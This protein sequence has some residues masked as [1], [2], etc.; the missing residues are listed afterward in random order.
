[1][2]MAFKPVSLSRF[3]TMD[4]PPPVVPS[5][6]ST[7]GAF[8]IGTFLGLILYGITVHQV[9]RYFRV[10]AQD[11]KLLKGLVICIF[12]I[13]TFH[14][15]TCMHA[16]YTYL[17]TNYFN[18]AS[19][20]KGTW[21]IQLQ[22]ITCAVEILVA[23]SFYSRRAFLLRRK[24]APVVALA[25]FC[26]F[27]AFGFAAAATVESIVVKTFVDFEKYTWLVSVAFGAA[28]ASDIL[29]TGMLIIVLKKS[30]TGIKQTDHLIDRLILYAVNTGLLTGTLNSLA[31]VLIRVLPNLVSF[32][33]A[34]VVT[35]V[36]ANS[37]LAVL[38]TRQS[39]TET[40]EPDSNSIGINFVVTQGDTA[41]TDRVQW[42]TVQRSDLKTSGAVIE[43]NPTDVG[44]G[45]AI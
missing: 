39:S 26:S 32:G 16:C 22:A 36:Y 11:R 20:L 44:S 8:L 9:H 4:S 21:S 34:V 41:L 33:I 37:V 12:T 45:V 15:I 1:M 24:N 10:Y 23:Q 17:V 30:R 6:D 43:M 18:P 14:M 3:F 38:N 31:L 27:I 19:L 13:E 25:V 40:G 35:Q 28:V 29:T 7:I 5:L 2:S 42:R